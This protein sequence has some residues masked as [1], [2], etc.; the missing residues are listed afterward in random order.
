MGNEILNDKWLSM[1]KEVGYRKIL[2]CPYKD[3]ITNLGTHLHKMKP[4]C[5]NRAN[6][7]VN[8]IRM[9]QRWATAV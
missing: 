1:N 6:V 4:D 5:F 9:K 7:T 2:R 3:L 8:I